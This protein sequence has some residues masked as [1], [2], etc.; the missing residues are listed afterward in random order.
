MRNL[1]ALLMVVLTLSQSSTAQD[2]LIRPKALGVS[3]F[4]NDFVTAQRIRSGTLS[5]VLREHKWAK[6]REMSPGLAVSYFKGV[7]KYVDFAGTIAFSFPEI[8]LPEKTTSSSE[9][10][11]LEADASLNIKLFSEKYWFTP[12]AIA[13]VG[14][15]KYKSYYG[16]FI[17]L[18][19][20]LKFN[21]FDEA[22]VFISSTYRVPVTTETNNYHFMTSIGISGIIG[23]K[24]EAEVAPQL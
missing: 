14:A 13:G 12:Y 9:A 1:L 5:Q 21:L 23:N 18:G 16:A 6:F 17:P 22:A 2:N 7:Q 10:L 19:L 3:F 4:F 20:G 15:S 11:L 24:K 8:S